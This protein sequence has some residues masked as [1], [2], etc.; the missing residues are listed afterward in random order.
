[1]SPGCF[2]EE[3]G[4]GVLLSLVALGFG[5]E[6]PPGSRERSTAARKILQWG[7]RCQETAGSC[8]GE[9]QGRVV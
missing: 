5:A 9:R 3:V 2:G 1:M 6:C 4:A 8:F 7:S